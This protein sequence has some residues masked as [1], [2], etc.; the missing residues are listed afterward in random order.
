MPV[1]QSLVYGLQHVLS[2]YAGVVAVPLIVAGA[3]KL[4]TGDTIYLVSAS[5]FMAGIAT[6]LQTIGVWRIGARQPIVQGTSFVSVSTMLAIIGTQQGGHRSL[7]VIYGAFLVAGVFGFLI[8]PLFTMLLRFFPEVVTGTVITM[9]GLSL[10]PVGVDWSAGGVGAKDYGAPKNFALAGI[11]LVI[12]V[13]IYRFAPAFLSRI[14]IL[15]GLVLGTLVAIPFGVNN[16]GAIKDAQIFQVPTPFHFGLPSFDVSATI[17][18]CIVMLVVMTEATADILALGEVCEKPADR[19]TVTAGVRADTLS[20][21]VAAVFNGFSLSAFAQNVGLVAITGIRSRFVVAFG[22]GILVVLGL[23][24]VLGAVVAAVPVAVLGGAGLALFGTV[25][26]S[27]IRTLREVDFSGNANIVVVAV[28]LAFGLAPIVRP[29]IYQRFPEW[30]QTIFDSGIT[31][32]AIMAVLL[33][34]LFNIVG[35]SATE[36]PVFAHAP[37]PGAISDEDEARLERPRHGPSV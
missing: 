16:F 29:E 26:A 19:E 37:A 28:S 14:A 7:Q 33:N 21:A 6:L 25:T 35:R 36:G 24:P 34:Y 3:A 13:L 32:A 9:I 15:L 8:A 10:I 17:S 22:G 1:P 30:F 11:T 18:M 27:G 5:L 12:I 31:S 20:T 4:S 23:F 2:M